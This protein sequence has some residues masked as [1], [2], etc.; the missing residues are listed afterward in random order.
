MI[1]EHSINMFTRIPKEKDEEDPEGRVLHG[2]QFNLDILLQED[3]GHTSATSSYRSK[4]STLHD[5]G[6]HR[7][8]RT[9]PPRVVEPMF[10]NGDNRQSNFFDHRP[11]YQTR[12]QNGISDAL[13]KKLTVPFVLLVF[14]VF[15]GPM[16]LQSSGEGLRRVGKRTLLSSTVGAPIISE[17]GLDDKTDAELEDMGENDVSDAA[18]TDAR[19]GR[20]GKKLSSPIIEALQAIQNKE[21]Q[22]P[23][24][25]RESDDKF[26]PED[27]SES[28]REEMQINVKPR[29]KIPERESQ[30]MS[31][32]GQNPTQPQKILSPLEQYQLRTQQEEEQQLRHHQEQKLHGADP[33]YQLDQEVAHEQDLLQKK[34]ELAQQLWQQ[35]QKEQQEQQQLQQLEL[36]KQV[37]LQQQQLLMDKMELEKLQK[38]KKELERLNLERIKQEQALPKK[39]EQIQQNQQ[40]QQQLIQRQMQAPIQQELPPPKVVFN[41]K[42]AENSNLIPEN[43]ERNLANIWDPILPTDTALFFHIPKSGGTTVADILT[44]CLDLVSASSIGTSE[45]HALEDTL[46]VRR[47]HD[48]GRYVNVNPASI[49]GIKHAKEMGL[50]A[51]G[52]ADV[53]VLHRLHE[54]SEIFDPRNKGRTFCMFRNPVHR[55]ISMFYYLQKA[56]WEPTYDPSLAS[57]TLLEYANSNKVEENWVTRFLVHQ[58]T[59]RLTDEAV[60]EAKAIMRNKILVGVVGNFQE[61]LKR[62]ELYF[63][64]WAASKQKGDSARMVQCQQN[65]AR[66]R[67]NKIPHSIPD[68]NDPAYKR[69]LQ[70]NWADME[71]YLYAVKLF[72]EQAVLVSHKDASLL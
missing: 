15:W 17:S 21:F 37:Q 48:H 28:E 65:H 32:S 55:A 42:H 13:V 4:S 66:T 41:Y 72:E 36:R 67:Q 5:K 31:S 49:E 59:G 61:S 24:R 30:G 34:Q 11:P 2:K 52:L 7:R 62:F 68:E 29:R 54:G 8:R 58:Y 60:D 33:G 6:S 71:L 57:M 10:T 20:G 39:S 53:V 64:W 22:L 56:T 1:F 26:D 50:A 63:D 25:E 16:I 12:G 23:E 44:H 69:L 38:E 19:L 9:T 47:Y 35:K 43:F 46:E 18:G 14:I 51:S 70:L 27:L 3:C 40:R 45:G